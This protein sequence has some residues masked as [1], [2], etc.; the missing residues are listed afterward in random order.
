MKEISATDAARGFAEMLDA[1]EHDGES[2]LIRRNGHAVARIEAATGATGRAVK[3]LL[4]S[5]RRD[6]DWLRDLEALRAGL[7]AEVTRWDA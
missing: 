6:G 4:A 2:F 3:D 5:T 1:I 7:P